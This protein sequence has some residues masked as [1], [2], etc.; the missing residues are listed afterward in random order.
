MTKLTYDWEFP[1]QR[2][3]TGILQGNGRL[4]AIIWGQGNTLSITLGRADLWDHRGGLAW[5]EQMSYANIRRC[6]ETNDEAG[7][8]RLFDREPAAQG[9]PPRPTVLPLGRFDIRLAA[10]ATIDRGT[11]E[12][13][14]GRITLN[15][16]QK[17]GAS[18]ITVDLDMASDS[19]CVQLPPAL[20]KA[21]VTPIPAWEYVGEELAQV[22]FTPPRVFRSRAATGWTQTLPADPAVSVVCRREANALFIG[23]A[24]DSTAAGAKR[25]AAEVAGATTE[26]GIAALREANSRWWSRYWH[27][28]PVVDIPNERHRFLY[29]YG[30][31]KFAGFTNPSGVPATLQGPWLEEYRLPPW[32]SDY[33]FNIN[34]QMCYQPAYHGNRLDH[35]VPLFDMVFSWEAQLRHNARVFLGIDDGFMLPHAVDDRCNCMGGFWSGSVDHGCTAWV[36][37]MMYRYYRYS[38]DR[39]FLQRAF[40]F[41]VGAMR[42]YEEMLETKGGKL[43]LPIGVS[44]EYRG[45]AMDAWGRNASF[46]LACIHALAEALVDASRDLRKKA[47]PA[48]KRILDRLPKVCIVDDP[49]GPMIGLWDGLVLEESHRHHSHLGAITPFD[50]IDVDA[51]EWRD[52]VDRSLQH[53]V[54]RGPGLWSGWCLP[55]A[56]ALHTRVGNGEAAELYI[57]I[58]DRFYTNHGHGTLHDANAAGVTLMGQPGIQRAVGSRG[59]VM[60][61]DGGMGAVAAIQEM[62]LHTKRGVNHVFRG[63][64]WRWRDCSFRGMRTDGAFIVAASRKRGQV[65]KV[66][67]K[68]EAGGTFRLARPWAGNTVAD[69]GSTTRKLTGNVLNVRMQ[70][71]ETVTLRPGAALRA[72]TGAGARQRGKGPA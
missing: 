56:S 57:D 72:T 42:V 11:L 69:T 18:Q 40:P 2:T 21:S 19:L 36:A 35:L 48:W 7:M 58:F 12:L 64:P 46:Q 23:V 17:R 14:N 70:P 67:V 44:P 54:H 9:D 50:T 4:G 37:L 59:D 29:W 38:M 28:V 6:L 26:T 24:R 62:L 43:S 61:M 34:V 30:M 3:H 10:D 60:Q 1:L 71:G 16:L 66:T 39:S 52:T 41:M 53:W 15:V 68:S 33:H 20:A 47:S 5:T 13:A 45:A 49:R 63:V 25:A 32:S 55:W 31:Y 27:G 51:P 65:E 8:R 22:A